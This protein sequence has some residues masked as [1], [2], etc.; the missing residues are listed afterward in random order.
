MLHTVYTSALIG[1]GGEKKYGRIM[2]ITSVV[3]FLCVTAGSFWF[4]AIGA[5]F[6]VVAAEGFSVVL[7]HRAVSF[8]VL[9]RPPEKFHRLVLCVLGMAVCTLGMIQFGWLWA[10]L[11]GMGSYCILVILVQAIG[12]SDIKTLRARFL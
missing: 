9:L 12:W 6:G 7:V 10:L 8:S 5:A 4:G 1:A 2:S 3:F 11:A